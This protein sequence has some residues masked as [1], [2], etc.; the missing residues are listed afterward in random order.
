MDFD[1]YKKINDTRPN[2]RELDHATV[3][4]HYRNSGCGDGYR[5]FLDIQDNKIQDASYTTTGCGF[6]VTALEMATEFIKN[7][8]IEDASHITSQDI[9]NLFEF[10]ERRKN[11][12]DSAVEA[13]RQA[14]DDYRSG[15]YTP[16]EKRMTAAKAQEIFREKGNFQNENLAGVTLDKQNFD[17]VNFSGADLHNAFLQGAS[18][19][20]ADFTGANL[21][22]AFLN[23]ADLTNAVLSGADLRWC[24]LSAAKLEGAVFDGAF[25]D[26]GTRIDSKWLH[27]FKNMVKKGKEAYVK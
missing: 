21:K 7:K 9:D 24:K 19:I 23:G 25:Y 18:L 13:I 8:S 14:I 5:V 15:N 4:S 1:R 6:S 11:Y 27:I 16:P 20:G 10:P 12:P 3:V 22:G 2:F 17:G 26:I